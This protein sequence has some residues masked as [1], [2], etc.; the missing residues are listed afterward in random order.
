MEQ[1]WIRIA[2]ELIHLR[3]MPNIHSRVDT[4]QFANERPL[5][6]VR[7]VALGS[8]TMHELFRAI[9]VACDFARWMTYSGSVDDE[10]LR[11]F[12]VQRYWGSPYA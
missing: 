11:R 2:M 4:W 1:L 5:Q 3:Y 10:N 7:H 8:R 6:D 12:F 9:E